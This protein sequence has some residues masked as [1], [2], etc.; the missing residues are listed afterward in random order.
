MRSGSAHKELPGAPFF[1]QS[2]YLNLE[3]QGK[4]MIFRF[5]LCFFAQVV[6]LGF[7]A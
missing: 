3:R 6:N 7:T 5:S 1:L 2:S 4:K